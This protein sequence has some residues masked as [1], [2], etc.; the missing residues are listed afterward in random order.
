MYCDKCG[1]E[2]SDKAIVCKNCGSLVKDI[3]LLPRNKKGKNDNEEVV[4]E[5]SESVSARLSRLASIKTDEVSV[6]P[7]FRPSNSDLLGDMPDDEDVSVSSDA[8][9]ESTYERMIS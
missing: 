7:R 6:N 9:E 1:A 2:I 4:E 3:S 5:R 8:G